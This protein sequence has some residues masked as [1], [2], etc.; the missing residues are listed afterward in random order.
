MNFS[1]LCTRAG[2]TC[3]DGM[4][5]ILPSGIC[6]DTAGLEKGQLFVCLRGTRTDGHLYLARAKERGAC[7]AII[8]QSFSGEIPEGLP[9]VTVDDTRD[10]V[11]RLYDAWHGNPSKQLRLVGV[12]GTNG[13]TSVSWI[14]YELLSRCGIPCGLIGTVKCASPQGEIARD[15]SGNANMTTPDPEA[16]YPMLAR[17]ADEGAE[18]VIMEVTSHALVQ[19]RC[20][21][22][23][24]D[25]GIFTNV[26]R[27]HLDFHGSMEAYFA[28]KQTLIGMCDRVLLNIDDP[29][30]RGLVGHTACAAY[31]C[32]AGSA[33]ADFY[34]K[35]VGM[36][37][38]GVRYRLVSTNAHARISCPMSGQ[39][40]VI[41]S[42]QA[43]AA[44]L[45][46]GIDAR[47]IKEYMP[48]I[49]PVPGRMERVPLGEAAGFTVLIDYAHTPDA[50]ENLLRAVHR[51]RLRSQRIVLVF[52]CGGDRDKGKRAA[53]GQI[54][55][56]MADFVIITADNSRTEST[57]DI[58]ADILRGVDRRAHY[59]VIRDRKSAIRHAIEHAR[60]HDVILLAG[61]GHE[62]YEINQNGRQPFDERAIVQE[63][64]EQLRPPRG[65]KREQGE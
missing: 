12:T 55:S 20:A 53:M 65:E 24:F 25:L 47:K 46:L 51:L 22:L 43:A 49:L 42:L 61:K 48:Q 62:N 58:I 59:R 15:V 14:L 45:I 35:D 28:A 38:G 60:Q 33:G 27:D 10:A 64:M 3:P 40:A 37:L 52:G 31:T 11:A 41:N 17:M 6:T 8:E 36:S 39:F 30:L 18:L 56:R 9:T 32:S 44:A 23:H 16:L 4:Q 7:A 57:D 34:A 29:R 21:P 50:L 2:L 54:A 26:T 5:D 13:K 19:K 1:E 63:A